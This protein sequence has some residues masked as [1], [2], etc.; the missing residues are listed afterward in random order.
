MSTYVKFYALSCKYYIEVIQQCIITINYIHYLRG[1]SVTAGANWCY[2][3]HGTC[4][5]Y[6]PSNRI[7]HEALEYRQVFCYLNFKLLFIIFMRN[8]VPNMTLRRYLQSCD[9]KKKGKPTILTPAEEEEIVMTCDL[10][11]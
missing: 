7:V 8:G 11:A 6:L 2:K 3:L 5:E 9:I 10:F 4:P 1:K